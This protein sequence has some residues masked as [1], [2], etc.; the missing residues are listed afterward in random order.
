[1]ELD[2]KPVGPH[3]CGVVGRLG[4]EA[5]EGF[6]EKVLVKVEKVSLPRTEVA[7]SETAEKDEPHVL[8]LFGE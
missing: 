3:S 4:L 7:K 2:S 8:A 6:L 5:L 1:M